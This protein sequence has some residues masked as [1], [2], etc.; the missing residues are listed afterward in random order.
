LGCDVLVNFKIM[1]HQKENISEYISRA[2]FVILFFVSL[3][4]FSNKSFSGVKTD[5]QKI[6][7]IQ[8]SQTLLVQQNQLVV[9][10]QKPDL[11]LHTLFSFAEVTIHSDVYL[12][13]VL[14]NSH[15]NEPDSFC[16]FFYHHHSAYSEELIL[17]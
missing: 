4:V 10:Q 5:K 9:S 7:T 17:S 16:W 11:L 12:K 2:L 8:F 6:N 3:S 14:Q 13:T 15:S 1:K